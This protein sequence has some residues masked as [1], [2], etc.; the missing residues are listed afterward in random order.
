MLR[1]QT[2][3]GWAGAQWLR[4]GRRDPGSEGP[5]QEPG[6]QG[7]VL[8]NECSCPSNGGNTDRRGLP[9]GASEGREAQ[10]EGEAQLEPRAPP[11]G[12]QGRLGLCQGRVSQREGG[13]MVAPGGKAQCW[14]RS[15]PRME[16]EPGP[17]AL[18]D[19]GG[20]EAALG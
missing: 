11:G 1:T 6:L 14:E 2:A 4:D 3:Q 17:R 18:G 8:G 19:A 12:D 13:H 7:W 5:E 15:E 10:V 9:D 16:G 20:A